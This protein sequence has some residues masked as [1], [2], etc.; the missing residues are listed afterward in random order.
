[1]KKFIDELPE[2]K[3]KKI[4]KTIYLSTLEGCSY[5]KKDGNGLNIQK[6]KTKDFLKNFEENFIS[7]V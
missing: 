5:A 4:F 6:I 1:M 3:Q 2:S 7:Q